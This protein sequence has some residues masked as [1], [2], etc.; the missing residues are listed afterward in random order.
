MTAALSHRY[1]ARVDPANPSTAN[2]PTEGVSVPRSFGGCVTSVGLDVGY[3]SDELR[4][5]RRSRWAGWRS[6]GPRDRAPLFPRPW[7]TTNS[8]ACLA[9]QTTWIQPGGS[10]TIAEVLFPFAPCYTTSYAS[11]LKATPS[12]APA[13]RLTRS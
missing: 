7:P 1:P 6:T 8:P 12:P 11:A 13:R 5:A 2:G 9:A 10:G 3:A 4:S